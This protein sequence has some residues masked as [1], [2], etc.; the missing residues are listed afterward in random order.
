M[1]AVVVHKPG[2]IRW[3]TVPDPELPEDWVRVEIKAVG[4][5]SSDVP[6]ALHGAAYHY[7]IV[8]G[9]EI[10]GVVKEVGERISQ[11]WLQRRV[12]VAPLIP[13]EWCEWC[14]QGRYSLCDDYDYLGSR[15]DGGCAEMVIA[16]SSN[17]IELAENIS[18]DAAALMEPTS[19]VV[20]ALR[21]RVNPGDEVLVIGAGPIGLLASRLATL[22]GA[23]R[24]IVLD[25]FEHR[26]TVAEAMG[27]EALAVDPVSSLESRVTHALGGRRP[28][29]VVIATGSSAA[30][31]TA[32][33]LARRG[34]R[35]LCVGVPHEQVSFPAETYERLVRHE[36]RVM[37]FW[38]SYSSPFPG[39]AWEAARS[40]ISS[41]RLDPDPLIS[42]RVPLEQ[43]ETAYRRLDQDP[44]SQVKVLL[45][46]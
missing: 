26:L 9:H 46:Q 7:P 32:L 41:G 1:R 22:L 42:E 19:V 33:R 3:E 23:K 37:G 2:D 36:L 6:R 21:D 11:N 35:I 18:F 13:C 29:M 38:N 27:A 25:R 24:V 34:G 45:T 31:G 16:P 44:G 17:L 12:A 5:C 39:A 28:D 20:H 30:Q 10:S 14:R 15:R 43:A 4:I 8:L 40:Y